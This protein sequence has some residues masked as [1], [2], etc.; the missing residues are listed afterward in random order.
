M[1]LVALL[2][3]LAVLPTFELAEQIEHEVAHLFDG[4][5]ADHGAH[6]DGQPG[7]EHG[8][9]GLV[10]LC[11]CHQTQVTFAAEIRV[12]RRVEISASISA[13]TPGSL[14]DLTSLEPPHRPPIA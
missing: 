8:C 14:V 12:S 6:H 13:R 1:R 4:E 10:H 2:V 5:P 3:L 11:S 7:D 9:T